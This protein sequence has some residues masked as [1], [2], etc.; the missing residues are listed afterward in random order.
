MDWQARQ[1]V[2]MKFGKR[3]QNRLRTAWTGSA[4]DAQRPMFDCGHPKFRGAVA[5]S[6]HAFS[7][8]PEVLNVSAQVPRYPVTGQADHLGE[9]AW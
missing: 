1:T 6:P 5:I 4:F 8:M 2:R 3:L 9:I 7:G